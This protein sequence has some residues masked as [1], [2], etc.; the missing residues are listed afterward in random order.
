MFS[1][2]LQKSKLVLSESDWIYI[3]S[4]VE[5]PT[6]LLVYEE[7]EIEAS[8]L[9]ALGS[10]LENEGT[11]ILRLHVY[12]N[13][14]K[15]PVEIRDYSDFAKSSDICSI[16]SKQYKKSIRYDIELIIKYPLRIE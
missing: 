12:H 15:D 14:Q 1:I 7:G 10:C 13:C 11:G 6:S 3:E 9:L 8:K 5:E 16:C 2:P 4:L